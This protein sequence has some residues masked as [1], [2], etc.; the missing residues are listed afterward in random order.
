MRS[1]SSTRF[2]FIFILLGIGTFVTLFPVAWRLADSFASSP[3][4][5]IVDARVLLVWPDHIEL[6]PVSRLPDFIPRSPRADY[7]FLVPPGRQQ[8]VIDGLRSYPTPT[9]GTSWRI[10]V[11]S[12][13]LDHQEIRLELLGDGIQGI[14]YE[15]TKEKILP[16][17]ARLAGPGFAFIVLGLDV[18]M[19]AL[20]CWVIILFKRYFRVRSADTST[21][22]C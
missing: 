15:A 6:L 1:D 4:N 3:W 5:S 7:S 12:L 18:A 14:V 11:K 19:S 17:K 13:G 16:L 9:D 8:S 10:S 22:S 21:T 2:T 20:F